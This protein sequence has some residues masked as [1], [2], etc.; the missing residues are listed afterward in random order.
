MNKVKWD[1]GFD[2]VADALDYF[3]F[4]A[5]KKEKCSKIK[6]EDKL[7]GV[8]KF[9]NVPYS[10]FNSLRVFIITL[11]AVGCS[12]SQMTCNKSKSRGSTKEGNKKAKTTS[13]TNKK[14]K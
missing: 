10:N 1:I 7:G 11:W 14:I 6:S 8:S 3:G 13:K 5:K 2:V 9:Q 4:K 12:H